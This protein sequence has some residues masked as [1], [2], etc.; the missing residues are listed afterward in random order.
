MATDASAPEKGPKG[1][2]GYAE[3]FEDE[4]Y[5]FQVLAYP[6][7]TPALILPNWRWMFV[8]SARR[9]A[10]RPWVW[11]YRK[12]Q[13]IVAHQGAIPVRLK[14]GDREHLTGWFV[15]T[16]AAEEI[17]GSPIG[18]MVIRKALDDLPF[19]LSLGQTEQMRQ[20]QYAMGWQK[21]RD[22]NTW[23]FVTNRGLDLRTQ[24][25]PIL[26][27]L[28]AFVLSMWHR[29][30]LNRHRRHAQ[31]Q[32]FTSEIIESFDESHDALWK[33]MAT[34]L[35]VGV[36]RDASYLNW[37]YVERPKAEFTRINV[38]RDGQVRACAVVM[39]KGADETYRY[40]RGFI[41]DLLVAPQDD[42]A[43]SAL[44]VTALDV[45][46]AQSAVSVACLL[47]HDV[48]EQSLKDFGFLF[49]GPRHQLL[50]ATGDLSR[51]EAALLQNPSDWLVTMGDSDV[52]AYAG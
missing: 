47:G 37:K 42:S 40:P 14:L 49:R 3:E 28:A 30:K 6:H 22:L 9:L 39:M 44:L 1:F 32:G 19:N 34:Q 50:V 51:E 13:R 43:V 18:P 24:L 15:E 36:V 33:E 21:V 45:L 17:R 8:E 4:V 10:S 48:L 26:A 52:D 46:A 11:M 31:E 5:D 41:V 38:L 12:S 25:P 35:P 2:V 20:L 29:L 7:R 27:P 23:L 16:M